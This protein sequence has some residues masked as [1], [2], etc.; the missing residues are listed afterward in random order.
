MLALTLWSGFLTARGI[1]TGGELFT[2]LSLTDYLVSPVMGLEN[3]VRLVRQ[4]NA[5]SRQLD[6]FLNLE[7]EPAYSRKS[8]KQDIIVNTEKN[9][10]E[11]TQA[12][13]LPLEVCFEHVDF[14]YGERDI[15]K[16]FCAE[17]R[18]GQ[19]H[20]IVGPIGS[21][22]TTLMKLITAML[23]P[24]AGKVRVCGRATDCWDAGELRVL[25]KAGL[26]ERIKSL[27]QGIYTSL[28]ENGNPLSQG[29][30]QRLAF[31][32]C[33]LKNPDIYILDEPTA[34]LDAARKEEITERI[35][36]LAQDHLVLV[37]T[38][39]WECIRP[40]DQVTELGTKSR[41]N[42]RAEGDSAER[43]RV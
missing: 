11:S 1:M 43:D 30:K 26:S 37:I 17:W 29:E 41:E 18:A 8:G 5:G 4:A 28:S 23:Y 15:L 3:T 40:Q 19:C 42:Q 38:H 33:I 36:S 34:S 9:K 39:D 7:K 27:P 32:R 6:A 20:Y 35:A 24:D 25:D 14:S 16:N 2:V 13:R 12:D 31:A 22:K 21:G 10:K